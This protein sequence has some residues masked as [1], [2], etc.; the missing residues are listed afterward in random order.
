MDVGDVFKKA[1]ERH[2]ASEEQPK[3]AESR[4]SQ[5]THRDQP[6]ERASSGSFSLG[7]QPA[8]AKASHFRKKRQNPFTTEAFDDESQSNTTQQSSN[9]GYFDIDATTSS[10]LSPQSSQPKTPMRGPFFLSEV[11]RGSKQIKNQSSRQPSRTRILPQLPQQ[12]LEQSVIS[13]QTRSIDSVAPPIRA[14]E[15]QGS[16]VQEATIHE[17]PAEVEEEVSAPSQSIASR[18]LQRRGSTGMLH[19]RTPPRRRSSGGAPSSLKSPNEASAASTGGF[20]ARMSRP[21]S[22]LPDDIQEDGNQD[23]G[24]QHQSIKSPASSKGWNVLRSKVIHGQEG[25][26]RKLHGKDISKGLS[27]HDMVTELTCGHLPVMMV[28]M[29]MDRDDHDVQRIPILL[30]YLKLRITDSIYPFSK[31]VY[32]PFAVLERLN[33]R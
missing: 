24:Q 28:K 33:Y 29:A 32:H 14:S 1:I 8:A 23:D 17:E 2:R 25:E 30:N 22:R 20:L 6:R 15:D 11:E 3:N 19:S 18:L 31:S 21:S 26:I 12:S 7:A 10:P 13:Q 16:A 27:G 5:G 4:L 9:G